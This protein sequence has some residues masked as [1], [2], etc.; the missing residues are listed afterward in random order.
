MASFLKVT[1]LFSFARPK[2]KETKR[3]S[4]R[5]HLRGYSEGSRAKAKKLASLEQFLLLHALVPLYASHPYDEAGNY[6]KW[7][8]ST[9][10]KSEPEGQGVRTVKRALPGAT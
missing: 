2:E 8:F 9:V 5:L 7:V 6:F 10:C 4:R 1:F 3:E